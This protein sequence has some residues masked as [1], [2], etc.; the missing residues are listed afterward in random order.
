MK[1][2]D[3]SLLL[4]AVLALKGLL[5]L[6]AAP[7]AA[8]LAQRFPRDVWTGRVLSAAAWAWAGWALYTMPIEFLTPVRPYIPFAALAAIPLTWI[9][10]PDLLSCRAAGCLLTL[11]PCPL[12]LDVRF[13]PSPW[14]LAL[15]SFVYLCIV[16]GMILLLY[17]WYLRRA[18]A[19]LAGHPA[20]MRAGGAATLLLVAGFITLGLTVLR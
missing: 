9:W 2:S 7:L 10:M 17:P 1:A 8:R 18:L 6:L 14:R 5:A 20:R 12:L 4:G 11:F 3:W 16:A 13:H 15:V 19:F